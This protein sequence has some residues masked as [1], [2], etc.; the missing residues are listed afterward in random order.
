MKYSTEIDT[1]SIQVDC[2]S[3]DEQQGITFMIAR[4]I[5]NITKFVLKIIFLQRKR[6]II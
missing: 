4:T 3:I 5:G 6:N 1:V 2:K